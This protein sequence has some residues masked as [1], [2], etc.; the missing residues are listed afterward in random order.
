MES[1]ASASSKRPLVNS[2]SNSVGASAEHTDMGRADKKKK[3]RKDAK[4]ATSN[5]VAEEKACQE[6]K[7]QMQEAT[8]WL[9]N[10]KTEEVINARLFNRET[11]EEMKATFAA[12]R[13]FPHAL[14][15]NFMDNDFLQRVKDELYEEEFYQKKN[16]LYDFVQTD[17]LKNCKKSLI[18]KLRELLLSEP[19]RNA[20]TSITGIALSS[21]VID[22][23]GAIYQKGSHLLCHDD[24][25]DQRRYLL[26]NKDC[27]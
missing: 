8:Q 25:L 11:V 24:E 17:D 21:L 4:A 9:S 19:F 7:Q 22:T 23:F 27:V 16:D 2:T 5:V 20:L 1:K 3:Q 13:P 15:R 14:I 18:S 26:I 6:H 10:L 12:E